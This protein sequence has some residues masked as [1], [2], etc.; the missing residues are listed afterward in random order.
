MLQ[1]AT[2]FD[3]FLQD[4]EEM[5]FF[6]FFCFD[7][8]YTTTC[9]TCDQV[10]FS[11]PTKTNVIPIQFPERREDETLS[12]KFSRFFSTPEEIAGCCHICHNH[13]ETAMCT[14]P[15][16]PVIL[17][18]AP[19]MEDW[20]KYLVVNVNRLTMTANGPKKNNRMLE[21]GNYDGQFS[22]GPTSYWPV[23]AIEHMGENIQSG[24]FMSYVKR[25]MPSDEDREQWWCLS[26]D[27]P[28]T[29]SMGPNTANIFVFKKS[30][31]PPPIENDDEET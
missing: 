10:K 13:S 21:I 19:H 12:S 4:T 14:K 28:P 15:D 22:T 5:K 18:Y 27:S 9:K 26:D 23:A 3:I 31:S 2:Y 7:L 29:I 11:T 30:R 1:V 24:H 16:D 20:P 6:S 17:E 25:Q 8:C